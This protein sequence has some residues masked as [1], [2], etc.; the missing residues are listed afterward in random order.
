MDRCVPDLAT[1]SSVALVRLNGQLLSQVGSGT[2]LAVAEHRF[3]VTAAHVVR[4]AMKDGRTLGVSGS[5]DKK[6][7]AAAGQWIVS[8]GDDTSE[9]PF[10]VA[11]YEFSPEE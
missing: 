6:F 4:S 3:V 9:D 11:I 10:D 8:G 1:R 2:L 5:V 7:V